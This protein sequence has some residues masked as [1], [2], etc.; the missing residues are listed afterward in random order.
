[1]TKD[2][3]LK[4]WERLEPGRDPFPHMRV[5]PYNSAGSKYGAC[6]VRI[7]GSPEFVDAV[8]SCLKTLIKGEGVRTRLE[9]AYKDVVAKEINGKRKGFSNA[10][11]KAVV[12]YVRLHERGQESQILH[13]I[14]GAGR[15][16]ADLDG[17]EEL[18]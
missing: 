4:H 11:P 6:G 1:M 17:M 7:D 14:T 8:L 2:E 15:A 3:A 18:F 16:R 5:I 9:L 10:A 12:C 13:A